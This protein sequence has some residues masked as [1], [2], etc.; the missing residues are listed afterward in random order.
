MKHKIFYKKFLGKIL[1]FELYFGFDYLVISNEFKII[2]SGILLYAKSFSNKIGS[3]LYEACK[4]FV[5]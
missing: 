1:K 5:K 4:P 3:L 2:I